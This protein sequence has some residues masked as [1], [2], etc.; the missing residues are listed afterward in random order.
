[1]DKF[2]TWEKDKREQADVPSPKEVPFLLAS[3]KTNSAQ[4]EDTAA[5][6][7]GSG[8]A[9]EDG[10]IFQQEEGT[11]SR[12][13]DVP[14]RGEED[15]MSPERDGSSQEQRDAA[16]EK[17]TR[18]GGEQN[19]WSRSDG[20]RKSNNARAG[21]TFDSSVIPASSH[22]VDVANRG[23]QMNPCRGGEE[24]ESEGGQEEEEE[25]EV[26]LYVFDIWET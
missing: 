24:E 2:M 1:M 14:I 10:V 23:A 13:A 8:V 20:V 19:V 21:R 12:R 26:G 9:V 15:V 7:E 22:E 6:R 11:S 16:Q 17:N 4:G 3:Q 25:D 5:C 18:G